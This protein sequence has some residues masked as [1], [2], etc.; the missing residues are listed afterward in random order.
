MSLITDPVEVAPP[1][2]HGS[3]W[4]DLVVRVAGA[5]VATW[6]GVLAA[7]YGGYLTP[8]RVG[9]SL[10][11]LSL[12]IAVGGNALLIW[13]AYRVTRHK[14]LGLLPGLVWVGLS[15]LASGRT[16][17]GDLILT[18]RNWVSMAYLLAGSATVGIAAYRMLVPPRPI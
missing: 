2:R 18:Q 7:L 6:G 13:F 8:F 5:I 4:L 3:G 10:V 15:F 16:T 1:P 14:F 9:A 11:P 12:L 17:E